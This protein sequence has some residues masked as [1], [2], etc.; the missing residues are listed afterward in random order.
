MQEEPET[1]NA[2]ER[3]RLVGWVVLALIWVLMA[4]VSHAQAQPLAGEEAAGAA[5]PDALRCFTCT[6]NCEA[7]GVSE[8]ER[9]CTGAEGL[10]EPIPASTPQGSAMQRPEDTA[11]P[12]AS[13]PDVAVIPWRWRPRVD[14]LVTSLPLAPDRLERQ[15]SG[16]FKAMSSCLNPRNYRPQPAMLVELRISEEGHPMAVHGTPKDM[17]ADDARCMLKHLWNLSF[18]L[19][20]E[21]DLSEPDAPIYTLSYRLNFELVA[22][23][24][25]RDQAAAVLLEGFRW[26][27]SSAGAEA[28]LPAAL[29]RQAGSLGACAEQLR[30]QLPLDLIVAEVELGWP[31]TPSDTPVRPAAM[32]LTLSNETGPEHPSDEALSC[33]QEALL[34]WEL[35]SDEV[36][37]QGQATFFVTIRPEGW[38]GAK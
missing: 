2:Q 14:A 28:S 24:P 31:T 20:V 4:G 18:E 38:I 33:I 1:L 32:D 9:V 15:L 17:P 16:E 21:P 13:P 27:G 10:V 7:Q 34:G 29:A 25:R 11:Q 8:G 37:G 30:S 26:R 12:S 35:P 6:E 19:P 23:E 5:A 3:R 36:G 22:T